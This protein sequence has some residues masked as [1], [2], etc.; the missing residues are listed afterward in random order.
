MS[1]ARTMTTHGAL[2]ARRPTDA[3][4]TLIE[5]LVVIAVTALLISILLPALGHVKATAAQSREAAAGKQIVTGYLLYS[6]DNK[7]TLLP[8]YLKSEW[9]DPSRGSSHQV[10]AWDNPH[11][12]S[13]S[14]RL[15]GTIVRK[16]PWRLAPYIDY[17]LES[18][19]VNRQ[20]Y[21]DSRSL[22]DDRNSRMGFQWAFS[23]NPSFGLNTTFVGGDAKRGGFFAPATLRWGSFYVTRADQPI[24]PDK[25]TIFAT[26]RGDSPSTNMVVPG[27]HRIEGPWNASSG[28]NVVPSFT[29]WGAPPGPFNPDR[30]PGTYGHLD[31]R[32]FGKCVTTTFDGHADLHSVKDMTDMRRW[33]NQATSADWHPQ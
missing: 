19:I 2:V 12:A 29:R 31:F 25:L 9:A 8:G 5:M 21:S 1:G 14:T 33:S 27:N 3:G 6:T 18:L 4:F 28:T 17:S 26:A 11:D 23:Q 15:T 13:D 10:L 22:P 30:S 32:H 7:G 20:L 16:Y 24:F